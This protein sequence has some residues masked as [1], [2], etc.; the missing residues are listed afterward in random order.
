MKTEASAQDRETMRA[1]LIEACETTQ[2][3]EW[4]DVLERAASAL[5]EAR[6]TERERCARCIEE[7]TAA[8]EHNLTPL[9]LQCL[10]LAVGTIRSIGKQR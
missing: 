10:A 6:Q 9:E 5:A 3:A 1:L 8:V 2:E 7:L 4:A